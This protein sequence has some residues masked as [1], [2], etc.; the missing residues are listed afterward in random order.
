MQKEVLTMCDDQK[1]LI[2]GAVFC[3]MRG[4]FSTEIDVSLV[5]EVKRAH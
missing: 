2:P 4:F 1:L 5:G 3:G